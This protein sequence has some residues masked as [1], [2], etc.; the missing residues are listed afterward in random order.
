MKLLMISGDRSVLQ[1]KLGAFFYTL[2]ELRKHFERID[3]ICP[4]VKQKNI[5]MPESGHRFMHKGEGGEVYF[6][7]C[8]RSLLFQVPWIVSKGKTLIQQHGHSIMTA[9]DYPPFYN[10]QGAYKLS[11]KTGV[12]YAL[13]VHHLVGWPK[14]ANLSERIGSLMNWLYMNRNC[15]PAAGVRVVNDTV[16]KKLV[17][18]GVPEKK[19]HKVS[20][21]YLDKDVLTSDIKPPVSYDVSFCGRLVANKGLKE[22]ILATEKL[23]DVR[24]LVIGDGP[25]RDRMEKLAHDLGIGNRVTFLGW[26]PTQ[27]AVMGA[28]QTARMFIMNS[29]SEGGPRIALEA[30]GSGMPVVV[31][32]VGVMPEIVRDGVNGIF[33]TGEVD[34]VAKKIDA[35]LRNDQLREDMA[36]EAMKVLDVYERSQLIKD[37]AD[38]LKGLAL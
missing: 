15:K 28:I 9:H 35:L 8:P 12:P 1:G 25:E 18:W 33:T 30:M 23:K 37:Y 38:F 5:E 17:T 31:T 16:K 20:S 13:E 6:H 4:R 24:L 34:D 36:K 11:R 7:P 32:P 19:I 27:E 26:L 2:Q 14:P 22:V 3:I 29:K 21:L 10:S